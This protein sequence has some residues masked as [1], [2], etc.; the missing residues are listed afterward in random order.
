MVEEAN[1]KADS[2]KRACESYLAEEDGLRKSL[3]VAR[4]E[5]E[6]EQR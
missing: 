6:E 1:N 5:L 4:E 2:I 3:R